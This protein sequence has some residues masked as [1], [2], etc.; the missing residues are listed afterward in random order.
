MNDKDED[1]SCTCLICMESYSQKNKPLILTCGHSICESC[2]NKISKT[3]KECPSCKVP[4]KNFTPPTNFQLLEIVNHIE[5]S[6][7]EITN[8]CNNHKEGD[9][10]CL[11]C[12]TFNCPYCIQSHLEEDHALREVKPKVVQ[13]LNQ[14]QVF[15]NEKIKNKFVAN[16]NKQK[17]QFIT[18]FTCNTIDKIKAEKQSIKNKYEMMIRDIESQK[19]I[20][21]D[22]LDLLEQ[23]FE[24]FKEDIDKIDSYVMKFIFNFSPFI[25][26]ISKNDLEVKEKVTLF[27]MI[28]ENRNSKIKIQSILDHFKNDNSNYEVLQKYEISQFIDYSMKNAFEEVLRLTSQFNLDTLH[29][30]SQ[31]FK[32]KQIDK[33][34][35]SSFDIGNINTSMNTKLTEIYN[36][37]QEN[38][39]IQ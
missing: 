4:F 21:I 5:K 15:Y 37:L 14:Y 12:G 29:H 16:L 38:L 30:F 17:Q 8:K 36:Y 22:H 31:T 32:F 25:S 23:H 28:E 6:K 24:K 20:A 34:L 13:A 10:Y 26:L 35:L 11:N 3:T 7:N 27:H 39:S 18:K 9:F 2:Y 33:Q 1:I 19:K